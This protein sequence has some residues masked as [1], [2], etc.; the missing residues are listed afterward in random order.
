GVLTS[1]SEGLPLAL[2][3]Y[4]W[5]KKPVVV[6]DVGEISSL[7]TNG[8]NGFLVAPHKEHLFYEAVVALIDKEFQQLE[9]GNL[10]YKKVQ[11]H[12]SKKAVVVQYLNWL[13]NSCK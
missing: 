8:E 6:T 2:L 3:E 7:I 11:D 5:L 9:F 10:L 12:Y 13:N 4:G 1:Q